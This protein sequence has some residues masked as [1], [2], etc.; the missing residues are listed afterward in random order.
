[1]TRLLTGSTHC[2]SAGRWPAAQRRLRRRSRRNGEIESSITA[3][4][5]E[6]VHQVVRREPLQSQT[7]MV[8][9]PAAQRKISSGIDPAALSN[10]V[11]TANHAGIAIRFGSSRLSDRHAANRADTGWSGPEGRA[12]YDKSPPRNTASASAVR[13]PPL[14]RQR[15]PPSAPRQ[16]PRAARCR[17]WP[18]QHAW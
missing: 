10:M 3:N 17:S 11:I 13:C 7:A 6:R 18:G 2:G 1:M 5:P 12:G 14:P 16:K 9:T 8:K 4:A 15:K